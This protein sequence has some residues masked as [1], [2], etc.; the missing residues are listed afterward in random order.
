MTR[1]IIS[2]VL[3]VIAL[4]VFVFSAYKIWEKKHEYS[5]GVNYYNEIASEAKVPAKNDAP[6]IPGDE[7]ITLGPPVPFLV[8]FDKLH[9]QNS[10][11]VAWIY[12]AGTNIDYPVVQSG[13]NNY[14]LRRMLSGEWNI[15]GTIFMDYR[16]PSDFSGPNA[17]IYGH[18]MNNGSMFGDLPGYKKQEYFDAHPTMWLFTPERTYRVDI[19]A[20]L[21]TPSNS[22]DVYGV[23]TN[24]E[25]L[26]K[27]ISYALENSMFTSDV[28]TE[29]IEKVVV[30]STCSYETDNSRFVLY[31]SLVPVD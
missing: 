30:L 24:D 9:E 14:Y 12:C 10:D 8:D 11:I 6:D 26:E 21:V 28:D 18:N 4:A 22:L 29:S 23:C 17:V 3:G 16:F 7:G 20:G 19:F 15:A 25:D 2:I 27:Y 1:K 13:D 5:V 31:G